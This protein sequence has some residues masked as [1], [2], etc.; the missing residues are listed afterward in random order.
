MLRVLRPIIVIRIGR[1]NSA[2]IGHLTL[3]PELYFRCVEQSPEPRRLDLLYFPR[4]ICNNQLAEM[5]RRQ[6]P[7]WR[8][9]LPILWL[10]GLID[11][12]S[13]LLPG[14]NRHA[15][16]LS[17]LFTNAASWSSS[18]SWVRGSLEGPPH[19]SFTSDELARGRKE[20]AEIGIEP[21]APFV[22]LFVRDSAYLN[23]HLPGDW[24]FHSYRDSELDSYRLAAEALAEHGYYV[25]RMGAVVERPF[26]MSHP[27]VIDYASL[28]RSDFMDIFL[29]AHCTFAV[30][31]SSG[32]E[33]IAR[34]FRRP[35]AYCNV[36]PLLT[37]ASSPFANGDIFIPKSY[38]WTHDGSPMK[39]SEILAVGADN[40]YRTENFRSAGIALQENTDEEILAVCEQMH[41]RI[42]GCEITSPSDSALQDEFWRICSRERPVEYLTMTVGSSFLH[43]H[44]ELTC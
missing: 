37:L 15:I 5:W 24:S 28:F 12:P 11:G 42:S 2:R 13:R 18:T 22:C 33:A 26:R 8:R 30:S 34:I 25:L 21:G 31:S 20:L 9:Q 23:H 36:A 43:G 10:A 32:P 38:A 29:F 39:L 6:L 19:I 44:P 41:R 3:E 40:F 17:M 35:N 16:D 27:R 14:R 7:K 4:P 1:V